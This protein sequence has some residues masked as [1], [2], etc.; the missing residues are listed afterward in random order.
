MAVYNS[1]KKVVLLMCL[2]A[3][4]WMPMNAQGAFVR[5][6]VNGD[7]VAGMDDLSQMINYLL[8]GTWSDMS[9]TFTVNGVSFKMIPVEGGSFTMG[10]GET[11]SSWDDQTPAHQVSLST[12]CIAETEVTQELWQAVMGNN[13]SLFKGDLNRPVERVSWNDCKTF[14][15]T[16][17]ELT[18]KHFR[19]P[20]EAEWEFAARGGNKSQG[21]TYAGSDNP[22]EV[23]W[24]DCDITHAVKTKLPNE[25]GL[26][27][28]S[29]NVCEWV[30]DW[31][32][33]YTVEDIINPS[34]QV[35]GTQRVIRGACWYYSGT[36]SG[37]D[38]YDPTNKH[39]A[40]GLRLAL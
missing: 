33:T 27:D 12:F 25:L 11:Q 8:T 23:A 38:S 40:I 7:G 16:L 37:R 5:G 17:N 3:L 31:Y 30:W 15:N 35:S 19:F 10:H 1:L 14:I 2:L 9:L 22:D 6:D 39:N 36:L 20:T 29:G 24:F 21:Y 28:M 26:Y 18:G 34:G 4:C 13:P 32:G